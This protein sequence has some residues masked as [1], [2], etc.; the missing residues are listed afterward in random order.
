MGPGG[1]SSKGGVNGSKGP[2][3]V[4]DYGGFSESGSRRMWPKNSFV[5]NEFLID[6]GSNKGR[7]GYAS[8]RCS[9]EHGASDGL[10]TL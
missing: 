9:F 2:S 1:A 3:G 6:A 4:E 8:R 10:R 7:R 5:L